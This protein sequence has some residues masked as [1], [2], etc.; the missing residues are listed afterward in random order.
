MSA[1]PR[2]ARG[3]FAVYCSAEPGSL[4][5][6]NVADEI[7]DLLGL[8]SAERDEILSLKPG[9]SKRFAT[10]GNVQTF[11]VAQDETF[12]VTTESDDVSSYFVAYYYNRPHPV[13][14]LCDFCS[15]VLSVDENERGEAGEDEGIC[16]ACRE[17]ESRYDAIREGK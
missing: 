17:A 13:P 16:E 10:G 5:Y 11:V 1:E 6:F 12:Y 9:Y 4:A 8:T 15:A 7:A 2:N 14:G 3:N